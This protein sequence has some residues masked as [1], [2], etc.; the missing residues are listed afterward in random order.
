M[1][2]LFS[3][4]TLEEL[5]DGLAAENRTH[6][7]TR[8]QNPT[9]E[10]LEQKLAQLERGEA[11][12][13]FGS[14]MAAISAVML[15][16]L[17]AGDHILF[18]NQTYGPTIQLASRLADFGITHDILLDTDA[19]SVEAAIKPNTRLMWLESPG[20]MTFYVLDLEAISAVARKYDIITC[21]DNS[22]ATPLLQKPVELG[23]DIVIHTCSKY[24]NGHSDLMA[25]AVITSE[26]RMKEIFYR[27]YMLNGGIISP[28]DAW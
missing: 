5:Q 16:V 6:V 12:K 10:A 23:V 8:G 22:W 19:A 17:K 3:F 26:T 9:V 13:C 21:I 18:V 1:T 2:S 28:H 25:G 27:S 15:G 14:G 20:T 11:C 4:P 24:I 7:Y